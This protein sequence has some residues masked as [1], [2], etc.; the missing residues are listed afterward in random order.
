M[1]R[2]NGRRP[3]PT[4]WH[5]TCDHGHHGLGNFGLSEL[6]PHL[7]MPDLG[8]M[9][10]LTSD[11]APTRDAVGPTSRTLSCDRMAYRYRVINPAV[12]VRWAEVRHLAPANVVRDLESYS[13]PASWW[14]S[15]TPVHL[16]A[17]AGKFAVTVRR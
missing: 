14:V 7:L 9:V 6:N 11:P 8:P 2:I 3:I 17:D 12:A 10:W 13:D 5:F 1:T 4:L 15:F 16:R